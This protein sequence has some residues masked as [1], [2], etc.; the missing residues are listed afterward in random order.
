MGAVWY[1]SADFG[2]GRFLYEGLLREFIGRG[3]AFAPGLCAWFAPTHGGRARR[4]PHRGAAALRLSTV[5]FVTQA[6]IR[7]VA[8]GAKGGV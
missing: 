1:D 5:L 7:H 8:A 4:C 2:S 3:P 6:S